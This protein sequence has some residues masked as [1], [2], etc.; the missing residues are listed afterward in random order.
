MNIHLELPNISHVNQYAEMMEEWLAHGGRLNPGALRN[1]GQPYETWLKWMEDD[2]REDTCPPEAVP[3]TMYFAIREDGKLIG[4]VTVR[5]RLNELTNNTSGGGHV[6]FGVRPTERRKGYAKAILRLALEKLLER[7]IYDV[8]INCA[9]DNIGSEKTILSCGAAH[10]DEVVNA[11]GE[12]AKRFWILQAGGVNTTDDLRFENET[13]IGVPSIRH[14]KRTLIGSYVVIPKSHVPTPFDL[15]EQEWIDTKKMI[16][17]IKKYLD[18]KYKPDGYN[19]GWN[20]GRTAGQTVVYA[21]LHIIPRFNDEPIA[22]KGI[23]YL[24]KQD[25]N[26]RPGY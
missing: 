3:Q 4:A 13:A 1:D 15:T 2:A 17:T 18:E 7:G 14:N 26:I 5:H 12:K 21:H 19:L 11:D 9:L 22:G 16:D 23:R 6:G 10:Q 8:M 25:E 24:F 20:V